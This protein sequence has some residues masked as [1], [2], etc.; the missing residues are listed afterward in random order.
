VN[1]RKPTASKQRFSQLADEVKR[2]SELPQSELLARIDGLQ[3]QF[4]DRKRVPRQP[5]PQGPP[6]RPGKLP[7]V[8]DYVGGR[9]HYEATL[10]CMPARRSGERVVTP[11]MRRRMMTGCAL[12]GLGAS[13]SLQIKTPAESK[14]P[15]DL[16][17]IVKIIRGDEAFRPLSESECPLVKKKS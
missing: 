8:K 5:G 6:G 3:R 11:C 4:D 2:G 13:I 7:S 9:V 10:S 12:L 17:K 15:W 14:D 16:V 1:L